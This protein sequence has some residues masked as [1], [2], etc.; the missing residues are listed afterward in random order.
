M[1]LC[2]SNQRE[3][4][5]PCV[6]ECGPGSYRVDFG[7]MMQCKVGTG[8]LRNV[9]REG[10]YTWKWMDDRRR[11]VAFSCGDMKLI[12]QSLLNG[13]YVFS[14]TI[15]NK[16]YKIDLHKMQQTNKH[17]NRVRPILRDPKVHIPDP[18]P[19]PYTTAL[20]NPLTTPPLPTPI[21]KQKGDLWF[22]QADLAEHNLDWE[23]VVK[24]VDVTG[25]TVYMNDVDDD[26]CPICMESLGKIKPN[27]GV[28]P[29]SHSFCI[30]CLYHCFKDNFLI[31]P[32]CKKRFGVVSGN[33]PPGE[34]KIEKLPPGNQSISGYESFGTIIVKFHFPDGIQGPEH[35]N[36]GNKYFGTT[37]IA[38][39]PDAPEGEE[40][41]KLIQIGWDR[42]LMFTIGTSITTGAADQVIWNGIHMKTARNG[43]S[44]NYGYPDPG[45]F[46]RVKEEFEDKGIS[47]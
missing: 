18:A 27:P 47:L 37:R 22:S 19:S 15:A 16:K 31:C 29:C 17:T 32:I 45:Y 35:P 40:V 43:G 28:L 41:L 11:W 7:R 10:S 14:I 26:D 33:M 20:P 5:R 12:E 6:V 25:I 36:P 39:L 2:E 9:K 44:S 46:G 23:K 30:P 34:L 1:G 8:F 13:I 38:Y 4:Y 21:Q 24:L 3:R 42:K